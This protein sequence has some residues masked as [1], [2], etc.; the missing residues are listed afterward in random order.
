MAREAGVTSFTKQFDNTGAGLISGFLYEMARD[1]L[2]KFLWYTL[3]VNF[4]FGPR[5]LHEPRTWRP[6]AEVRSHGEGCCPST[7]IQN[8]QGGAQL[9]PRHTTCPRSHEVLV[10]SQSNCLPSSLNTQSLLSSC[11]SWG[12]SPPTSARARKTSIMPKLVWLSRGN[13]GIKLTPWSRLVGGVYSLSLILWFSTSRPCVT[14]VTVPSTPMCHPSSTTSLTSSLA[15]SSVRAKPCKVSWRQSWIWPKVPHFFHARTMVIFIIKPVSLE[16]QVTNW[17]FQNYQKWS[18]FNGK[19]LK[20]KTFSILTNGSFNQN[21]L[22]LLSNVS[23]GFGHKWWR[24]LMTQWRW[25]RK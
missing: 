17:H 10:I 18:R 15:I 21:G 23:G 11:V 7:N 6:K 24:H 5:S 14:C 3:L 20:Q 1:K 13:H 8:L 2:C 16:T 22:T 19:L 4:F 12:L 9:F 25:R